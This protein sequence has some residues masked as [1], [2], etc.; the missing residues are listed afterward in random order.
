MFRVRIYVGYVGV[1]VSVMGGSQGGGV[2]DI[3]CPQFT[4]CR[5]GFGFR[6]RV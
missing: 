2:M 5:F 1:K 4:E 6:V 3:E